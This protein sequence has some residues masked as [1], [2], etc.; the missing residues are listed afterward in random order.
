[1]V[2]MHI[3]KYRLLKH[4]REKNC[5]FF[6]YFNKYNQNNF[7]RKKGMGKEKKESVVALA[8]ANSKVW[9]TRLEI[10]E[11]SKQEYRYDQILKAFFISYVIKKNSK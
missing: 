11:R 1:M 2:I 8:A 6:L 10:S 3:S 5:V 4:K 7:Y 9:E